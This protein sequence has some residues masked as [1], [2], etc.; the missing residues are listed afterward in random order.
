MAKKRKQGS[1]AYTIRWRDLNG[2][3]R[4]KVCHGM[5]KK[6]A[7][8]LKTQIL[9]NQIRADVG[10]KTDPNPHGATVGDL[11]K[12]Y[13]AN[14]LGQHTKATADGYRSV[15]NRYVLGDRIPRKLLGD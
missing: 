4:S 11:A 14:G 7:E 8:D 9:A 10:A 5:T 2:R 12:W 6:Q 13:L 1:D 3:H 15:I